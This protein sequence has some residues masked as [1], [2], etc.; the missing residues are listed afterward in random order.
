VVGPRVITGRLP[1]PHYR[2]F[3]EYGPPLYKNVPL[4]TG[5]QARLQPAETPP[6]FCR[7]NEVFGEGGLGVVD[8]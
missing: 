5:G 2:N 7:G 6:N 4:T 1:T 3:V 8:R